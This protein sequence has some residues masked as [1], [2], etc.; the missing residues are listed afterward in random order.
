[1]YVLQQNLTNVKLSGQNS[2]V[3]ALGIGQMILN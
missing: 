1:M 3:Q 2:Q